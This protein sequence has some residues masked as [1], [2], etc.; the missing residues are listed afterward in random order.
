MMDDHKT[1][2]AAA[3]AN[4][5]TNAAADALY[6]A[7]MA[8]ETVQGLGREIVNLK[9][10]L[11]ELEEQPADSW[12]LRFFPSKGDMPHGD[13]LNLVWDDA[14]V[15]DLCKADQA[16]LDW[17][18]IEVD[19]LQGRV[20]DLESPTE[21]TMLTVEQIMEWKPNP[22]DWPEK[23][24]RAYFDAHGAEAVTPLEFS[25]WDDEFP[26]VVDNDPPDFTVS[27]EFR[28]WVLLH[29]L[30][31]AELDAFGR[32]CALRVVHLWHAPSMMVQCLGTGDKSLRATVSA[33]VYAK[34]KVTAMGRPIPAA[35]AAA[36]ALSAIGISSRG[37]SWECAWMAAEEA[38]E[39]LI[40]QK[41]LLPDQEV[42]ET[43]ATEREAQLEYVRAILQAKEKSHA[44]NDQ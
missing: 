4:V 28:L 22:H 25:R 21:K 31:E 2:N 14:S 26:L 5:G 40:D 44:N 3:Y 10:R 11:S 8:C 24:L 35:Y 42:E 43:F 23:R 41:S 20:R 13:P 29:V 32:W 19:R 39:A 1:T 37:Q 33:L 38:I 7:R 34:T 36:S 17:L 6:L 30:T 18:E 9:G 12:K 15:L 16:R 27:A